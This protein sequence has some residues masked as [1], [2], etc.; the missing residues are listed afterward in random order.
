[1]VDIINK[2]FKQ[3]DEIIYITTEYQEYNINK[4]SNANIDEYEKIFDYFNKNY[5]EDEIKIIQS[6]MYFGRECFTGNGQEY[7]G[8]K[9]KIISVWMTNLSFSIGQK[10]K[11]EVE[12]NQM[13]EKGQMIGTYFEYG[14][15]ELEKV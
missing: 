5:N 9:Y 15:K 4:K 6:I 12:I 2:I 11:K 1:M 10:I 3:K 13:L 7:K 8:N 14:F